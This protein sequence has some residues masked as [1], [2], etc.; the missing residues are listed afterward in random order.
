MTLSLRALCLVAAISAVVLTT[1]PGVGQAAAAPSI[2]TVSVAP[3]APFNVTTRA[4]VDGVSVFWWR[5]LVGVGEPAPTSYVVRRRAAG[6]DLT[7]VESTD[8]TS[9][10][11]TT[12][13][14][15]LP[16]GVPATYTVGARSAGGDSDESAPAN[17]MVP[18]WQGPYNPSRK[19]LTMVWDEA[20]GGP[21]INGETTQATQ[22]SAVPPAQ[23]LVNGL[24]EFSSG[25]GSAFALPRD[26]PDG[27]YTVGD[28]DGLL[29]VSA[30]SGALCSS[31]SGSASP[32]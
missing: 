19:V 21:N 24:M 9:T 6:H 13:D 23:G 5:G 30:A 22:D 12:L 11:K 16:V 32:G 26:L 15:T 20:A 28:G 10:S 29:A 31:P 4:G 18:A 1:V 14:L 3:S 8:T 27:D 7:W 25:P 2:M 17:A